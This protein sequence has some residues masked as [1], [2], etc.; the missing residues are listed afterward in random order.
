MSPRYLVRIAAGLLLA[1]TVASHAAAQ[2]WQVGNWT[3]RAMYGNSGFSGC[4]MSVTYNSGITLQFVQL[5]SY[6]LF[7]GMSKPDWQMDPY[8]TYNMALVIDGQYIR[9]ARGIVLSGLT[10]AIFL[11]LGTDRVTRDLLARRFHLTLV[12]NDQNYRFNLTATAAALQRLE[13]CIQTQT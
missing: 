2:S 8:A 1:A 9:R 6:A 11:D 4:R 3:G 7:I 5:S 12:N 13:Y 10:N